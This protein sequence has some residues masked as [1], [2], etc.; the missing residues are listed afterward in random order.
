MIRQYR[1]DLIPHAMDDPIEE[2]VGL[3]DPASGNTLLK[4]NEKA[5]GEQAHKSFYGE[6]HPTMN[7]SEN[8]VKSFKPP[9][10]EEA[11]EKGMIGSLIDGTSDAVLG[12]Y[13]GVGYGIDEMA[14]SASKVLNMIS[15]GSTPEYEARAISNYMK[16][17][18]QKGVAGETNRAV[19]NG[20]DALD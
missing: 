12:L 15:F 5:I 10:P 6:D 11:K 1:S 16:G 18:E 7:S 13:A 8:R 3:G 19:P 17:I 4:R 2:V 20:V 14:V 9:T